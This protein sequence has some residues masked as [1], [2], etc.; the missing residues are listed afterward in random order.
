[1]FPKAKELIILT[2]THGKGEAPSNAR[3]FLQLFSKINQPKKPIRYSIVGFGSTYYPDFCKF[4]IDIQQ[5]CK[6]NANFE[7][8]IPLHKVN[9][10]SNRDFNRWVNKWNSSSNN[11]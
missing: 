2:S 1:M 4:A 11:S 3:H 7:E 6:E 8:K 9:Q 10:Q 5:A